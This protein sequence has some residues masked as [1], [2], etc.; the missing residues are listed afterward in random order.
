MS[1][2]QTLKDKKTAIIISYLSILFNTFTNFILTPMY[3]KYLG[4]EEYGL[5]QMVYSMAHYILIM[6]FGITTTMTRFVSLFKAKQDFHLEEKYVS[7]CFFIVI[8]LV[9]GIILIGLVLN[10][11][12]IDIYP[13]ITPEEA[14]LAHSLFLVMVSTIAMVVFSHFIEGILMAY[15]Y[16]V[17]IKGMGLIKMIL[18]FVLVFSCLMLNYGTLPIAISDFVC[19]TLSLAFSAYFVFFRMKYRIHFTHLEKSVILAILSFMFAIFLQSVVSYVNNTVDKTILGIMMGKKDVAIYS[20]GL[21]F[22]TV[23]NALPHTLS[24][25]FLPNATRLVAKNA[26]RSQLTEFVVR[27]GR[28]QFLICGAILCGFVLFG[29]E[30]IQLWTKKQ[31]MQLAWSVALIIMVPNMI[32]LITG[33][34]IP[35]LDAKNKRLFRSIVML[36]L[37][38][39]NIILTVILVN[40]Y[41]AIGAPIGTGVS[42]LIGYGVIMSIYYQK[43]ID[44]D[45]PKMF[46]GII[47]KTWLCLLISSVICFPLT[48]LFKEIT[49]GAFIIKVLSFITVLFIAMMFFGFSAEERKDVARIKNKL[50]RRKTT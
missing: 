13:S 12:L 4:I 27:P 26:S 17:V 6:D 1:K 29:Q 7:H 20:V 31:E 46:K 11:F 39:I 33:T 5:Y 42:Y 38:A 30:F 2:P 47:S 48:R 19:V 22:I 49:W 45:V 28:Y 40:C 41:G 9:V 15:E 21:T 43:V 37:S 18:K 8:I 23:F 34:T 44:I 32:P 16:F 50:L 3:L 36:A 24:G 14:R 25:L 35:I 10:N